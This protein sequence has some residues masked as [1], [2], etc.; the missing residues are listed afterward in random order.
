MLNSESRFVS[1]EVQTDNVLSKSLF[2]TKSELE[3]V[4]IELLE[5]LTRSKQ[6]LLDQ[7]IDFGSNDR[8]WII[9]KSI[10]M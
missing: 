6:D 10:T 9:R 8:F 7:M 4:K 3:D 2:A 5:K 1:Q